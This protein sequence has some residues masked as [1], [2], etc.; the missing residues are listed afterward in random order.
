MYA[1]ARLLSL[2][3]LS[4]CLLLTTQAGCGAPPD[5][6]LGPDDIRLKITGADTKADRDAIQAELD[7]MSDLPGNHNTSMRWSSG[8]PLTIKFGPVADPQKF[9]DKVKFG[10]VDKIE[11]RTVY[12]T[13]TK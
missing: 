5:E 11:D 9:A 6:P 13:Y 2:L 7:N 1:S 12:I 4:S 8:Q 10:Q 3:L